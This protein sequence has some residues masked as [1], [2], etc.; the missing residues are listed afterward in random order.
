MT[1]R[2]FLRLAPLASLALGAAAAGAQAP[3]LDARRAFRHVE[4]LVAIGPRPSGSP[5]IKKARAYIVDELGRVGLHVREQPFTAETPDGPIPMV[6]VIGEIRGRRP[7]VIVLA[8][9]YDTKYFPRFRFVGAN[10]SGSSTGL[11][12]EL[13]RALAAGRPQWSYWCVFFDGEEA[14]REWSATDGIHGSRH[15]AGRL[16][17]TR[18]VRRVKAGLV[19]DMI[20]DADLNI[21][22]EGASTPWLVEVLWA[23]A[24]RLGYQRHFLD[25]VL[26]VED[27]HAPLVRLGIPA[28]L[29]IDFDY[30]GRGQNAY[31]HT[32]ED[33]LDKISPESLRIVGEVVLGSLPAIERE[34]ARRE[35]GA[36]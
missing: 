1:R 11:L 34:L 14:R 23:T 32:P 35:P 8:S 30:G 29:L 28:A 16:Q 33:T 19:L 21:R 22:R 17:A 31:W 5:E 13:A 4:R 6:N 18:D 12:L 10:D 26:L 2:D 7:E 15:F 27:D 20:G 24:R 36:R 25:E 3:R 9:H